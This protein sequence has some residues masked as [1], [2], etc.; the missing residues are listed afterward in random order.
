MAVDDQT[1]QTG[2]WQIADTCPKLI[3]PIPS[4]MHDEKRPGDAL[5]V[6][7]DPLNDVTDDVAIR[8]LHVHHIVRKAQ[9]TFSAGSDWPPGCA[10]RSDFVSDSLATMDRRSPA[11]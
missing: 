1:L 3:E 5:K 2:E 6:P 9:G 4:R 8:D 10:G 11:R 7:G